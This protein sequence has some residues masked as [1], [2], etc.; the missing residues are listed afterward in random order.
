MNLAASEKGM[1]RPEKHK[2]PRKAALVLMAFGL[3]FFL[4]VLILL[5]FVWFSE[6]VQPS[7]PVPVSAVGAVSPSLDPYPC[8]PFFGLVFDVARAPCSCA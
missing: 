8:D 3:G 4:S 2:D 6:P 5:T 1:A 7:P